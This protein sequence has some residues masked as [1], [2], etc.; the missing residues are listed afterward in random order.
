[1]WYIG[2]SVILAQIGGL[3]NDFYDNFQTSPTYHYLTVTISAVEKEV[4]PPPS[5]KKAGDGYSAPKP[6]VT[7]RPYTL[8]EYGAMKRSFGYRSGGLGP[9]TLNTAYKSKVS[10]EQVD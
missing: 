5:P 6:Q 2:A 4:L 10:T 7:Y 1:M 3:R 9:D 8:K